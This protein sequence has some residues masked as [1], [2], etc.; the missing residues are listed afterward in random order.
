M[1]NEIDPSMRGLILPERDRREMQLFEN[2]REQEHV[3]QERRDDFDS[4]FTMGAPQLP[5]AQV[6]FNAAKGV[7]G[8]AVQG[9]PFVC[10]LPKGYQ[11]QGL[12]LALIE[13]D[14]Y[15]ATFP[16]RTALL[17]DAQRGTVR[18]L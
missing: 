8:V 14:R 3:A 6:V 18:K 17:I 15:V 4:R 2:L 10:E 5:Q 11:A 7:F 12:E 16:G 13:G 9:A 1:S